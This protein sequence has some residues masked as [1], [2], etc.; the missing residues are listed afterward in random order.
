MEHIGIDVHKRESQ[1]CILTSEH[2]EGHVPVEFGV[3]LD[4]ALQ[5]AIEIADALDKAHRQGWPGDGPRRAPDSH[6]QRQGVAGSK[7]P[8]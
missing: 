1:I 7:M 5:I 6:P 3:P 4:Q 2:L 8:R